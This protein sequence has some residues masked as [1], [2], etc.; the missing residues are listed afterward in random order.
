MHI[1]D[2]ILLV[3][4]NEKGQNLQGRTL[5]QKKFYFLS[6][7]GSTDFGFGPHYYDT[8]FDLIAAGLRKIW[9]FS[10]VLVS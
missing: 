7:L 1:Q 6:V 10:S 9:I 8:I 5:L 4:G 2:L 3:I